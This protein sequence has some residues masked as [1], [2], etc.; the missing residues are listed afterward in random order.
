MGKT[1]LVQ[2]FCRDHFRE[3]FAATVGV[4]LQVK[5]INIEN[6]IIGLQFWDTVRVTV[7]LYCCSMEIV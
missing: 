7:F 3:A 6:Q 5:M 2:R 1:S 4:D